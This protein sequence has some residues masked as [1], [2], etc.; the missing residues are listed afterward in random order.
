M[1]HDYS[2]VVGRIAFGGGVEMAEQDS[3]ARQGNAGAISIPRPLVLPETY[4]GEGDWSGWAEQFESVAAVNGWKEPKKLP[5]LRVRLVGRSARVP[6]RKAADVSLGTERFQVPAQGS[7]TWK[8][9][10]W[11]EGVDSY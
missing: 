2:G 7:Y 10:L 1:V 8:P 4:N 5:W 9:L 11:A 3:G 6:R